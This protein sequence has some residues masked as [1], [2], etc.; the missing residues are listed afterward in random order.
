MRPKIKKDRPEKRVV[1][2]VSP[3]KVQRLSSW[4]LLKRAFSI[5][6]NKMSAT[7]RPATNPNGLMPD[8]NQ[9]KNI[10]FLAI[11]VD[12]E[13]V[14]IMRVQPRMASIM[15]HQPTF[16]EFDPKKGEHPHIGTKYEN[17]KLVYPEPSLAPQEFKL[18]EKNEDNR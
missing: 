7:K 15:L 9:W 12:G 3:N 4:D 17:G 18:G 2:K 16:V 1:V 10:T 11:V 5:W 14:D 6:L 13:V 8:T